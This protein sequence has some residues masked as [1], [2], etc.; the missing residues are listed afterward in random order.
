MQDKISEVVKEI[1]LH[2]AIFTEVGINTKLIE[3]FDLFPQIAEKI[4]S[5]FNR[6]ETIDPNY[7]QL[8]NNHIDQVFAILEFRGRENENFVK[9][10]DEHWKDQNIKRFEQYI[11]P[12]LSHQLQSLTFQV[13]FFEK[14]GTFSSN[15]V[16]LGANGSGKTSLSE[17]LKEY[18]NQNGVVISAQRI[19]LLPNFESVSN[20]VVTAAKLKAEQTR[21][22]TYK[23]KEDFRHLQNEFEIVL[24]HLIAENISVSNKFKKEAIQK[25]GNGETIL[26]PEK[27]NLDIAFEIWNS[28]IEHRYLD[29]EDG[30]TI[31]TYVKETAV[32]YPSIQMSD[33]E[34]VLL[35][36]IAQVLLAPENG[37]IV[38]DEPEMYLHKTILKRLWDSL[39]SYRSDCLFIYL[40]HDLDFASSRNIAKKIWIKSYSYPDYWDIEAIESEE[41]PEPLL[42]ELI[43][44]RKNILFC[45]GE[46]G[47][48]DER[49]Y[50]QLFPTYTISPVGSCFN[51]I[52][53]TKAFNKIKN[54]HIT[55]SGLI[56]SDH[57][58]QD[59]LDKI[60]HENIFNFSVAE[61]ENLFLDEE[62]LEVFSNTYLIGQEKINLIK[63]EV[64]S[65]LE[66]L[67]NVQVS[68]FVSTKINNIFTDSDLSQGNTLA[69]VKSN[70]DL[71]LSLINVEDFFEKRLEEI[72]IIIAQQ[73]YQAALRIFNNKGLRKIAA[74]HFGVTD[75][76]DK[77]LK[78]LESKPE[79]YE[80]FKKH[81]PR[82][83]L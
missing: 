26:V 77:S 40:T 3:I 38:I 36:L 19:L 37:F 62:F 22:K 2:K 4:I 10:Q 15:I 67:K 54:I 9:Y 27:T 66:K 24:K 13:D 68:N 79:K 29:C 50:S 63:N 34:K 46:K 75:F 33:G 23:D 17:K 61:I 74:K 42:F 20:P 56:D 59:R 14:I 35:Y 45:E 47:S 82:E 30:I 70:Y 71:F 25:T 81:F 31:L 32:S 69:T 52:N 6:P 48:L 83:L 44:S 39:E 43:G 16:I 58:S 72:N 49:I 51:V 80:I 7:I 55:A 57:H 5:Q 12:T 28:L 65:E 41:I 1:A 8:Y 11:H 78:L 76:K 53:H 60:K 21:R 73:D 18:L 64:I